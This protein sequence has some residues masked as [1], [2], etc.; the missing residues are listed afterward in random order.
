MLSHIFHIALIHPW[1]EV[2]VLSNRS[3]WLRFLRKLLFAIIDIISNK[4]SVRNQESLCLSRQY[5]ESVM[6]KIFE[7]SVVL[8]T[9]ALQMCSL[10]GYSGHE[11]LEEK[12]KQD[13]SEN[14]KISKRSVY[15]HPIILKKRKHC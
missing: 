1:V 12:K 2:V 15:I 14:W 8:I 10:K 6:G 13:N 7:T 11:I 4:S 9:G 5:E 3:G